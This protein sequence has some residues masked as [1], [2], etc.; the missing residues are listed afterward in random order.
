M[1]QSLNRTVMMT[2]SLHHTHLVDGREVAV[3]VVEV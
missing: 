1:G 2:S 3:D